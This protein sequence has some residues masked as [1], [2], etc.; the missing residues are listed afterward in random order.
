MRRGGGDGGRGMRGGSVVWIASRGFRL[1][2]LYT[3][4]RG[5]VSETRSMV[6][7]TDIDIGT[8][9]VGMSG[10]IDLSGDILVT[11]LTTGVLDTMI[12]EPR[13]E[14]LRGRTRKFVIDRDC[15]L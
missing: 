4:G 11:A 7:H 10:S 14:S 5:R 9:L 12:Q 13:H 1:T 8:R 2:G 15:I 3:D 6:T